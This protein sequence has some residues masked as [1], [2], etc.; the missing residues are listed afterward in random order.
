MATHR[1]IISTI[2]TLALFACSQDDKSKVTVLFDRVDKVEK[3]GDVFL[4]GI[5]VG[6][7]TH[8]ELFGDSVLVDIKFA[9]TIKI[10]V[11]SKFI[12]YSSILGSSNIS[13]ERSEKTVF[14]TN[15][16]T[17]RGYYYK[18]GLFDP[19]VSDSIKR[20]IIQQSLDKIGQGIKELAEA[21]KD[22]SKKDTSQ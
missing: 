18:K 6:E 9:D 7:V 15:K 20:E 21:S 8:L 3:G 1:L 11:D 16:D 22:T 17:A 13:I 14:L 5:S 4:K 19:M 10:P 2:L 12:I